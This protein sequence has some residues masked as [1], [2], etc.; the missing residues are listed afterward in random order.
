MISDCDKTSYEVKNSSL[1]LIREEGQ[2][3]VVDRFFKFNSHEFGDVRALRIDGKPWFV[4]RDVAEALRYKNPSDAVK[5]MVKDKNKM[6][7]KLSDLQ[8]ICSEHIPA[9]LYG[10]KVALINQPG[11]YEIILKCTLKTAEPFQD[12][13]T[14][15]VIPAVVN[16]G[17]YIEIPISKK[18]LYRKMSELYERAA[19]LEEEKERAE[20]E[21]MRQ[22]AIADTERMEKETALNT[23]E[24][25]Q[26]KVDFANTFVSVKENEVLIREVAKRLEQNGFI[27]AEK[28]LRELLKEAGFFTKRS[29]SGLWELTAYAKKNGYGVYRHYYIDKYSG[30]QVFSNTVYMTGKGYKWLVSAINK[31]RSESLKF[32]KFACDEYGLEFDTS[33]D[34]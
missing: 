27:I 28:S 19:N 18:E 23:I 12:W 21:A 25:N 11:L 8:P 30:E 10:V 13:V 14:E 32:G 7:V 26:P 20:E 34:I 2:E 1:R 4:G 16:S 17:M 5:N 33:Q 3:N 24:E 6:F 31:H 9:N 29:G 22:K 15:E